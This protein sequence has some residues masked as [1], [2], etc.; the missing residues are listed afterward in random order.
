ML[1]TLTQIRQLIMRHRLVIRDTSLL[2]ATIAVVVYVLYDVD[3]FV[4]GKD[5]VRSQIDFDEIPIIG[6]VLCAGLLLLGWR[7]SRTA[8]RE[9]EERIKSEHRV[10][11]L[12]FQDPLTGLPNRRQFIDALNTAI[13]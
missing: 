6:A 4:T 9:A 11:E 1:P 3:V 7:R 10:R 12:A 5:P 13:N 2:L 8:Q